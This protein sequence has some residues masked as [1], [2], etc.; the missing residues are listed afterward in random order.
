MEVFKFLRF[1]FQIY[2]I[3]DQITESINYIYFT[4]LQDVSVEYKNIAVVGQSLNIT[5]GCGGGGFVWMVDF[6]VVFVVFGF[7]KAFGSIKMGF[8]NTVRD[9]R[10]S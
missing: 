8:C 3:V 4:F 6:F 2:R 10:F 5:W 1:C 7:F 9:F